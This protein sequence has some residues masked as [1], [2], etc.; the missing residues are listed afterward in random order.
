M[1]LVFLSLDEVWINLAKANGYTTYLGKVEDY[2]PRQDSKNIYY[3][4][5][6]SSLGFMD[7]GINKVYSQIMFKGV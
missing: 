3:I 4:S 7:G 1:R 5:P 6:V 2:V